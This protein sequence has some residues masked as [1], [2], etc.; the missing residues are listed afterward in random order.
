MGETHN[1][2]PKCGSGNIIGYMGEYECMDCGYKFTKTRDITKSVKPNYIP[3]S[4]PKKVGGGGGSRTWIL[5]LL[6]IA[7]ILGWLFWIGCSVGCSFETAVLRELNQDLEAENK[8]LKEQITTLS[9]QVVALSKIEYKCKQ[10]NSSYLM[11]QS[12]YESLKSEYESALEEKRECENSVLELEKKYDELEREYNRLAE[13]YDKLNQSYQ[14][15][16]KAYEVARKASWVSSDESLEVTATL[17]PEKYFGSKLQVNVKN[18]R[19]E[20]INYVLVVVF[21]WHKSYEDYI[22]YETGSIENLYPGET[23][24]LTFSLPSTK[25]L[26]KYEI[27]AVWR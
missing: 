8:A 16:Y 9:E 19:K 15:L 4:T 18:L 11:L 1:R 12:S 10:L 6:L 27:I 22:F 3:P 26:E 20:P 2:C 5:I 25:Y 24:S 17:I 7:A 23:N 14:D 13:K 21:Y